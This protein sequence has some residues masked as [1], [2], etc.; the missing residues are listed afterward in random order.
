MKESKAY[1]L[2]P[3][4]YAPTKLEALQDDLERKM[5]SILEDKTLTSSEKLSR[6]EDALQ[7]RDNAIAGEEDRAES[8]VI[9]KPSPVVIQLPSSSEAP[10]TVKKK[11]IMK[12]SKQPRAV[13]NV[14]RKPIKKQVGRGSDSLVIDSW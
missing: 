2:V 6:Y 13:R 11:V 1:R 7:R 5:M 3:L 9:S 4:S 8:K 12:R 14:A 10:G